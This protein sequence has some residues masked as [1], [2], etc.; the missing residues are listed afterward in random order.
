[1][2]RAFI[3]VLATVWLALTPAWAV[4]RATP[5]RHK[6]AG[7]QTHAAAG[8][9]TARQKN[10]GK[11]A[12]TPTRTTRKQTG[13][14]ATARAARSSKRARSAVLPP[15]A[16]P[17]APARSRKRKAEPPAPEEPEARAAAPAVQARAETG[18]VPAM[19]A[20]RLTGRQRK[21]TMV[22]PLRGS[23]ESLVRQNEK[24]EDEGLDRIADDE[25]LAALIERRHLVPV[26][27]GAALA[28]NGNL[29]EERRYCRPW[30]ATFLADLAA[31]H[32]RR[33]H[34]GLE[35]SS[36]VR[37]VEY[38]KR[39]ERQN[40]NAAPA[41]GD[42]VSPHLTG[43]AIDIAKNGMTREEL[44]W[45]RTWLLPIQQ[46]GKL[47]VEEEFRQAC[48]HITVY[49]SYAPEQ[50]TPTRRRTTA[51]APQAPPANEAGE[52]SSGDE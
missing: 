23:Y 17:A 30:T 35:V 20:S 44:S 48:F 14:T 46:A 6:T 24:T 41:E 38:Q 39:L 31:A 32:Q 21:M 8:H 45:M 1:M 33:F 12:H 51:P 15:C 37:T 16:P 7:A 47:D 5:L 28:I 19:R 43:A 29:P 11:T 42:V 18:P 40:G 49:K 2:G 3:L 25:Q 26:P 27:T 36:A 10:V 34:R 13:K 22:S 4:G 50:T 52:A 9:A